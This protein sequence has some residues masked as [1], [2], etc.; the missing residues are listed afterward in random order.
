MLFAVETFFMPTLSY[1][2]APRLLLLRHIRTWHIVV[3]LCI[4]AIAVLANLAIQF[5][6]IQRQ[7][8]WLNYDF[9]ADHVVFGSANDEH[10]SGAPNHARELAPLINPNGELSFAHARRSAGGP[11]RLVT[12][13]NYVLSNTPTGPTTIAIEA[14]VYSI[15]GWRLGSR[16]EFQKKTMYMISFSDTEHLKIFAGQIDPTDPSHF[17]F[18]YELSSGSTQYGTIDCWLNTNDSVTFRQ[19]IN[20]APKK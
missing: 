9:P 14:S 15:A 19:T 1:G 12:V 18:D 11:Q 5:Q 8:K 4:I 6:Y 7:R 20:P 2:R 13:H 3:L 10:G 16:A 17:T